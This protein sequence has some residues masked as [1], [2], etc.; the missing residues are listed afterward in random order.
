MMKLERP[1]A[2]SWLKSNYKKWGK[3]FARKKGENP[4]YAF[5]WPSYE[6]KR[7]NEH[8]KP[9]LIAMTANHCSFCDGYPLGTAS[10]QTIEHFRPKS[11]FPLLACLWQNLFLCCDACQG[12]KG[13]RFDRKLLKPDTVDYHFDKYFVLNFKTGD[14]RPNPKAGKPDRERAALTIS[15]YGLNDFGRS[16]SRLREYAKYQDLVE[17]GYHLDDFS[18]RFFLE[19]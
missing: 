3:R 10:R 4:G 18:Y 12:A 11:L 14:I 9:L 13:E 8:L 17:K 16:H 6:G 15:L 2:P 1:P 5:N 7:I 19:G